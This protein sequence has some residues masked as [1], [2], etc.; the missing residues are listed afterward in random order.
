LEAAIRAPS[1]HN[2]QPWRFELAPGCVELF[3][4]ESRVLRVA[5]PDGREAR[6]SCGAALLNLRM[7]LRSQG[8]PVRVSLLPEPAQLA[9]LA[10]VQIGGRLIATHEE[11]L[12]A[13]AVLRRRTSRRPF[14]NEPISVSARSVLI[15]AAL[16]EGCRLVV[17][18]RPTR[19]GAVASLLCLAEFTQRE[20]AAFMAELR[21]WIA[22]DPE[23]LDGVPP[24]APV[25]EPTIVVREYVWNNSKIPRNYEREPLLGILLTARDFTLD[26]LRAGLAMQRILLAATLSGVSAAFL[27]AAVELPG[28]RDSLRCLSGGEG[29]PQ[30]VLRFGYGYP[31]PPTSRRPVAAVSTSA[32]PQGNAG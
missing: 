32:E 9:F 27:S 30:A 20:D 28:S 17:V 5:D 24:L 8:S 18:D 14:R 19:Y 21:G 7:S 3:L 2:T 10:R 12:L 1:P 23:R 22:M 16:C 11:R 6:M 29:H 25:D 4:D 13:A 15:Q 31:V 26:H